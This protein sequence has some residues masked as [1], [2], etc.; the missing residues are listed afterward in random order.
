MLFYNKKY[1]K[2]ICILILHIIAVRVSAQ[3]CGGSWALQRPLTIQCVTGQWIG[4]QNSNNPSGCPINPAFS[5]VQSNTFTFTNTVSSFTIDF[6]A[7]DGIINCPKIEIKI[8]GLFYPLTESNITDFPSGSLCITGSFGYVTTTSDGYLTVSS[9][10]GNSLSGHG[11]II[12]TNVNANNITISTNDVNGTVF[13]DPFN[14]LPVV[15]INFIS[16]DVQNILNCKALLNWRTGIEFNVKTIEIERRIDGVSFSKV[17][18]VQPK[19]SNSS[20]SYS[21]PNNSNAYFRLKVLDFDGKFDYSETKYVKSSCSDILYSIFP[22]PD[23]EEIQIIGLKN[24]DNIYISDMLGKIVLKCDAPGNNK[25]NIQSLP[26][27]FYI[28]QVFNAR[29]RVASLKLIRN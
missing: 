21:V 17:A 7:L 8:N 13:S 4:W 6:K 27:G 10:G 11:R 28:L 23:L 16:F 3:V 9:L 14:C 18:E 26:H 20:Y 29:N 22:N 12:I 15:P 2:L 5:G 19:G 25:L 1:L 24:T